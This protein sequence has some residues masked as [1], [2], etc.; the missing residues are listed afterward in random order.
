MSQ[1][2]EYAPFTQHFPDWGWTDLTLSPKASKLRLPLF[3][4]P[5]VTYPNTGDLK[6]RC[7]VTNPA[8]FLKSFYYAIVQGCREGQGWIQGGGGFRGFEP[9]LHV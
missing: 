6:V 2:A 8:I 5:T 1:N 4:P 9:P 3:R 7:M